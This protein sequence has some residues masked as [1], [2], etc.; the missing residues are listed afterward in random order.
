MPFASEIVRNQRSRRTD[1]HGSGQFG[2]SRDGGSRRHPGL[3]IATREGEPVLSPIEGE[4]TREA[5]PY[6]NDRWFRGLVIRG[7]AEWAGYEIKMF[8]VQG[9]ICGRVSPGSVVGYAQSVARKHPG[10]TDHVH[11]EVRLNGSLLSP[12]DIFGQCL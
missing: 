8:Y 3:D 5:F 9:I 1:R 2:S 6:R 4:V 10:I 12:F 11:L 7:V